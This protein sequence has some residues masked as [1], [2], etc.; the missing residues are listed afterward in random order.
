MRSLVIVA[1][2]SSRFFCDAFGQEF[3]LRKLAKHGVK[4]I[5]I[6]QPLGDNDHRAQA[7][8]SKVIALFDE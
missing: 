8:M 5:S 4:L 3:Y 1:R 7:M 2:R 6:T